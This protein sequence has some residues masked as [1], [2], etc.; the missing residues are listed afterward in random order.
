[1]AEE[2]DPTVVTK[3]ERITHKDLIA[4][5]REKEIDGWKKYDVFRE[6]N[7]EDLPAGIRVISSR[8]IDS[9]KHSPDGSRK[10]KSRLVVL[11]NQD[12]DQGVIST[13]A[14]TASRE[15]TLMAVTLVIS[16][17][18]NHQSMNVEK[19]F[20][21]SKSL[22]REV[23][24]KPPREVA[25]DSNVV[26]RMKKAAHGLGDAAKEWHD[27]LAN[28]LQ[29]VGLQKSKNEPAVFHEAS[30]SVDMDSDCSCR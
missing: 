20:L 24:V 11:G 9:W 23:F 25:V 6:I 26:W 30:K 16:N 1:M 29:K 3:E 2:G 14:P 4:R 22:K 10:M 5:A 7:R 21:Q 8:F 12:P 28:K 18:W 15:I 27:T 19:A 17:G 13:F